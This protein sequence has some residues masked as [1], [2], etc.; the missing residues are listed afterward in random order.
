MTNL[1]Y[2]GSNKTFLNRFVGIRDIQMIYASSLK[3]AAIICRNLKIKE[4]IVILFEECDENETLNQIRSF[5]K[6][7]YQGY[8]ILIT[9]GLSPQLSNSYLNSGINDTITPDISSKA[10]EKK[11]EFIR[12]RQELLYT[13]RANKKGDRQTF[14]LPLWKRIFDLVFASLFLVLVSPLFLLIAIAIRLES[15]GP[16]IYKSKR[17]GSNYQIFDFFKFRSMIIDADKKLKDLAALNQYENETNGVIEKRSTTK[18]FSI[19][20]LQNIE[21]EGTMFVSDDL[22][23][24]KDEK[25]GKEE[26]NDSPFIKIKNDPRIT[27]VGRVIR[28]L[29]LDE[30][31]QLINILKGDMSIVGNRPLPL[32]EA[33]RLTN[34][35]S[36]ERFLAPAGLTGLWQVEKRG[37]SGSLSAQER[38]NLDIKYGKEFSF[39]L[40]IKILC[41]TFFS[42]IQEE[43]V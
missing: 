38:T 29:S 39:W 43:N 18:T 7:F 28:K 17:V 42:F 33:E 20:D 10:F 3:D 11:L 24:T 30:L 2:I 37:N 1:L 15:R 26:G 12:K 21:A 5:R 25:T 40:D 13:N 32:Y 41:K 23:I 35:D 9:E 14:I 31:P 22:I 19:E 27:K 8:I 16:I 6:K 4:N 34:D 36:I